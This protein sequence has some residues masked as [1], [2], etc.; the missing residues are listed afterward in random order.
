MLE[1]LDKYKFGL[2]AVFLTYMLIFVYSSATTFT[3]IKEPEPFLGQTRI[4]DKEEVLEITPDEIEVPPDYD[5]NL[6]AKNIAQSENDKREKS[7]DNFGPPKSS[8]QIA[9]DIKA[10]EQQ[11]KNEAGG[12]KERAEIQ[13]LIDQRKEQQKAAQEAEKNKPT[14]TT[15]GSEFAHK[16]N[17]MVGWDLGDRGA[18]N[19]NAGAVPIPGYTC[20]PQ[21]NGIVIIDIK[22]NNN[23][24]VI[25][26]KF[27][28]S[29]S[30][31]A[32]GC[33]IEQ[34]L[35]YAKRARFE[36]STK[37]NEQTGYIKYTFVY[38]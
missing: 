12:S 3:Y 7:Y 24:N 18:L 6:D 20:G 19:N 27:N 35:I 33:M 4:E 17:N 31:N 32:N 38:K 1:A 34:A 10:L 29:R 5:L 26:A 13:Q 37:P 14:P 8:D 2:V 11:M 15:N 21:A 23:G 36:Y 9:Q 30:Q 16:G 28:A 25:S 22:T